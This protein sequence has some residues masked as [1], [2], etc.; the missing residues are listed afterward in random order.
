MWHYDIDLPQGADVS[1]SKT[2]KLSNDALWTEASP[3]ALA[4]ALEN[5]R[6]L[7][8][9]RNA[10]RIFLN[11]AFDSASIDRRYDLDL[12]FEKA[13]KTAPILGRGTS[14]FSINLTSDGERLGFEVAHVRSLEVSI[15]DLTG[16]RLEG[17]FLYGTASFLR[18][19]GVVGPASHV[20]LAALALGEPAPTVE[21]GLRALL[22]LGDPVA[23]AQLAILNGLAEKPGAEQMLTML[24]LAKSRAPAEVRAAAVREFQL[25]ILTSANAKQDP[26]ARAAAHYSI[27]NFERSQSHNFLALA[28]YNKARKLRPAYLK[29]EYF[30]KELGSVLFL[31]GKYRCAANAYAAGHSSEDSAWE[32]FLLGDALLFSGD[33]SNATPYF[34]R[35][36]DS[37]DIGLHAEALIKLFLCEWLVATYGKC[38][39]PTKTESAARMMASRENGHELP[40]VLA[41]VT[42]EHDTLNSLANFNLGISA[43]EEGNWG[44]ALAHFLIVA[45][46]QPGD[47]EAWVNAMISAHKLGDTGTFGATFATAL[48]LGGTDVYSEF[49]RRQVPQ[50]PAYL[51]SLDQMRREVSAMLAKKGPDEMTIRFL[52]DNEVEP[53]WLTG[54]ATLE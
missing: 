14:P 5:V 7:R 19:C 25:A 53:V 40:D 32:N 28:H 37:E 13:L 2:V 4:Q 43:T 27:G 29:S 6:S 47:T 30:L 51:A 31:R 49:R 3:Q 35:A 9:L 39:I 15:H 24:H 20:A 18:E 1:K 17:A 48:R 16:A 44:A 36:A 52:G 33:I 26:I 34:E 54:I 22:S 45:F 10:S 12:T 41:E 46:K 8:S 11:P 42:L 21:L 50:D 38:S 23:S